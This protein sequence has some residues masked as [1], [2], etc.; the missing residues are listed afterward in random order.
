MSK[1]GTNLSDFG[2]ASICFENRIITHI[3]ATT[4][5][6]RKGSLSTLSNR[7]VFVV[8]C[9]LKKRKIEWSEWFLGYMFERYQDSSGNASLP[10]GMLMSRIIKAMGVDVSEFPVKEITYTYNDRAFAN[11]SSSTALSSLMT[12]LQEDKETLGAVVGDMHKS[13]ESL[14]IL[15]YNVA[16]L[17]KQLTLVQ[18][19]RV[20]YFNK[21]L[22]QAD[23]ATA[24]DKISDNELSFAI[25][26]SYSSQST[27]LKKFYHSFSEHII[28]MLKYFLSRA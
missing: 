23:L 27:R 5:L 13:N 19:E 17:K 14:A 10:Y 3:V 25:Q 11:D 2:P 1:D 9:L 26:N 8:Y 24:Q 4:L 28:N 6:P 20:K 21:V 7:D 12:D 15:I 16:D 18:H 22:R